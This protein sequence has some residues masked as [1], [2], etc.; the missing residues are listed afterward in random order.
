MTDEIW[1]NF[2]TRQ[3]N[4]AAALNTRW[5]CLKTGRDARKMGIAVI[6]ARCDESMNQGRFGFLRETC[7]FA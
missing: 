5:I 1:S 2:G 4:L 3:T 6:K 7:G